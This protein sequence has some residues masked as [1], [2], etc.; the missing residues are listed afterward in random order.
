MKERKNYAILLFILNPFIGANYALFNLNKNEQLYSIIWLLFCFLFGYFY[1]APAEGDYYTY[2]GRFNTVSNLSFDQFLDFLTNQVDYLLYVALYL[3]S[4]I[5]DNYMLLWGLISMTFGYL[6]L[7]TFININ[8]LVIEKSVSNTL[9]YKITFL[10]LIFIA[11]LYLVYNFRFWIGANLIYL[12]LSYYLLG[13]RKKMYLCFLFAALTHFS[14]IFFVVIILAGIYYRFNINYLITGCLL[15][16]MIGQLDILKLV[17]YIPDFIMDS[18]S[19]YVS[20]EHITNYQNYRDNV[21]W[22][23]FGLEKL[24][25]YVSLFFIILNLKNIKLL[26]NKK[27]IGLASIVFIAYTFV[28]LI[29]TLPLAERFRRI[30]LF[31]AILY[32]FFT[33]FTIK[34]KY[35]GLIYVVGILYII[36]ETRKIFDSLNLGLMLPTGVPSLF[37]EDTSV[38]DF[39]FG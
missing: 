4:F 31:I 32:V 8:S 15:S 26:G 13:N 18:R 12:G 30:A 24:L 27:L 11:S 38:F 14:L 10:T 7:R 17:N 5:T 29:I 22:Y 28:N 36:V 23:V 34:T 19:V 9:L 6:I 2:L 39:L 21:N 16:I 25:Y 1:I 20:D 3:F 37:I 35:N 33:S